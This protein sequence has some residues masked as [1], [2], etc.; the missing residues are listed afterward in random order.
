[1]N[2]FSVIA[3]GCNIFQVFKNVMPNARSSK[4]RKNT[5]K[6]KSRLK[7]KN[8]F[9]ITSN[10]SI[11]LTLQNSFFSN[12]K[13]HKYDEV[14]FCV[15]KHFYCNGYQMKLKMMIF[16]ELHFWKA[17]YFSELPIRKYKIHWILV[18]SFK[19]S[20]GNYCTCHS[21]I[22]ST[23]N[24]NIFFHYTKIHKSGILRIQEFFKYWSKLEFWQF[25][26]K[27]KC[28]NSLIFQP[29]WFYV[30]SILSDFRR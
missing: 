5:K 1:M 27:P 25:L 16:W 14:F 7:K 20:F 9:F 4:H 2:I 12:G 8:Q 15:K 3:S 30:K 22:F 18:N 24:L 21:P 23:P 11:F 26:K 6:F 13:L 29:L 19:I 28:E 10:V 17:N